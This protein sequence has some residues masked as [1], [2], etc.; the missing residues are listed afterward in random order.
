LI[1][2]VK[3][4]YWD[5]AAEL[6]AVALAM[7]GN[8][9]MAI[10]GAVVCGLSRET[11]LILPVAF[12]LASSNISGAVMVGLAALITLAGVRL[13]VGKRKLYCKRFML[14]ENISSLKDFFKW[15]PFFQSEIFIS[16]TLTAL[17]IVSVLSLPT[18]WDIPL[19]FIAAVWS[20]ALVNETHVFVFC[21]PWI[22]AMLVR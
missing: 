4:D 10:I 8:L 2:T 20:M 19:V 9:P 11:A 5:W 17:S 18:G 21:L 13:L 14:R 1:L 15:I 12:Y 16:V 22:A 6:G 7:T 3:F